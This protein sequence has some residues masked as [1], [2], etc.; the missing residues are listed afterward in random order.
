MRNRHKEGKDMPRIV[1]PND[2][3]S[4]DNQYSEMSHEDQLEVMR[5]VNGKIGVDENR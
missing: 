2:I 1:Y 5:N 4:D 3:M